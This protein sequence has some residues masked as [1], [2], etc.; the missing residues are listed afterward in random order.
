MSDQDVDIGVIVDEKI[1]EYDM[2]S[3]IDDYDMS[4]KVS[5]ALTGLDV[6]NEEQATEIASQAIY[7]YDWYEVIS[8]HG[9]VTRDELDIDDKVE[10]IVDAKMF[11]FFQELMLKLFESDT[12]TWLDTVKRAAVTKHLADEKARAEEAPPSIPVEV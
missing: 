12:E 4:D 7:D 6:L 5:D 3:K 10:E 11:S 9:L 8:D 1:E 2:D